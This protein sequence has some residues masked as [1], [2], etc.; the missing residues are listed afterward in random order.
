VVTVGYDA[1]PDALSYIRA[2]RLDASVEQ[3]PGRQAR[4]ALRMLVAHLRTGAPPETDEV[5]IKPVVISAA[6]LDEAED[7][8]VTRAQ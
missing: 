4:E 6:N 3:Y 5:Y 7:K 2:G 1:I 8:G